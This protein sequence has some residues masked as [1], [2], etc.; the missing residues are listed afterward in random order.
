MLG[1]HRI[2]EW[3]RQ[4]CS[5]PKQADMKHTQRYKQCLLRLVLLIGLG[6]AAALPRLPALLLGSYLDPPTKAR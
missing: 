3:S 1:R 4:V 5:F 6:S 2:I